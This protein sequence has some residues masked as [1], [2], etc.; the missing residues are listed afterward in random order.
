M[1]Y[2]VIFMKYPSHVADK[3]RQKSLEGQEKNLFPH[4]THL[5]DTVVQ[6]AG[7]FSEDGIRLLSVTL[8]KEGKLREAL[9][10]IGKE[11]SYMS[12]VEGFESSIEV[13]A[14]LPEQY[15]ILGT[16]PPSE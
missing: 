11:M 14:T 6:S 7:K 1:P 3:V 16:E 8:A 15:E 2:I 13:W 10:S 12:E 9:M 4:D 5:Q